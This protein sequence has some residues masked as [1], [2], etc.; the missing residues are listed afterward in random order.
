[1]LVIQ[2][3]EETVWRSLK[4]ESRAGEMFQQWKWLPN[5][6]NGLSFIIRNH[7]KSHMWWLTSVTQHYK[8]ETVKVEVETGRSAEG[9]VSRPSLKSRWKKKTDSQNIVL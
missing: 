9:C 7:L 1:L 5:T 2:A 3:I 8:G 6:S 4:R